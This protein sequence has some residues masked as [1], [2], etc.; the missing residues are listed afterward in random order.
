MH[1]QGVEA[2]LHLLHDCYG[3]S[4]PGGLFLAAVDVMLEKQTVSEAVIKLLQQCTD[5]EG[6]GQRRKSLQTAQQT[7]PIL[8][9]S[10]G[11]A[12]PC[13]HFLA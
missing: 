7:T 4:H 11:H 13:L 8:R 3:F 6:G 12:S 1:V 2:L 10:M 9:Q 5:G